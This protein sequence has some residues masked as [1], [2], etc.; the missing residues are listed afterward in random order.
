MCAS[1]MVNVYIYTHNILLSRRTTSAMSALGNASCPPKARTPNRTV[2]ALGPAPKRRPLQH[3][4]RQDPGSSVQVVSPGRPA[5]AKSRRLRVQCVSRRSNATPEC[6]VHRARIPANIISTKYCVVRMLAKSCFRLQDGHIG[7][8]SLTRRLYF[9]HVFPIFG[10][11]PCCTELVWYY[12]LLY[13]A[14][15]IYVQY[16]CRYDQMIL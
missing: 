7:N 8:F 5:C 1:H 16:N 10:E 4:H 11:A 15:C 3:P 14:I 13:A 9:Q 2:R 6:A 12:L